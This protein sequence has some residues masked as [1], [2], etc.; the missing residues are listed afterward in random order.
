MIAARSGS[1]ASAAAQPYIHEEIVAEP[2]THDNG[3][4]A[5][6]NHRLEDC[7]KGASDH[8]G[9]GTSGRSEP[10]GSKQSRVALSPTAPQ[11]GRMSIS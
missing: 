9:C 5:A 1:E 11:R 6:A 3:S 7:I 2:D 8:A 10:F 4:S